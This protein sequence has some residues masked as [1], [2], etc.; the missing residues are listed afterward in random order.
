M[1]REDTSNIQHGGVGVALKE[2]YIESDITDIAIALMRG[3]SRKTISSV[4]VK[5]GGGVRKARYLE[6]TLYSQ[7]HPLG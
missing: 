6:E 4:C 1:P 3:G 7:I 5:W 2:E